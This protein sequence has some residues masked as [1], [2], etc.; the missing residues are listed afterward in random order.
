MGNRHQKIVKLKKSLGL[1]LVQ[2]VGL[3][4]VQL[5]LDSQMKRTLFI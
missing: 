5:V 1:F 4:L 3:I 2:S